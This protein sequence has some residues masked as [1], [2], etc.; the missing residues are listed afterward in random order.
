MSRGIRDYRKGF[1]FLKGD[2]WVDYEE[3]IDI[4]KVFE[5]KKC[6]EEYICNYM[7]NIDEAERRLLD[8]AS[9]TQW[10]SP[11]ELNN[12]LRAGYSEEMVDA[13]YK[14]ARNG[15][16]IN[17]NGGTALASTH[18]STT[19]CS[20]TYICPFVA[21]NPNNA[22]FEAALAHEYVHAFHYN[23]ELSVIPFGESESVALDVT[24][25]VYDYYGYHDIANLHLLQNAS[26][27]FEYSIPRSFSFCPLHYW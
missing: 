6:N 27:S 26:Y 4:L 7:Q 8:R 5:N 22:I 18:L 25:S 24:M 15:T 1:S 23:L 3:N 9:R 11:D 14:M 19:G 10:T 20:E 16:Y 17:P 13:G 2:K 21:T 12:T